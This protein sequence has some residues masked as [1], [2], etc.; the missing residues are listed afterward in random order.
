VERTE[1]FFT[2][3]VEVKGKAS[4]QESLDLFIQADILDGD[5]KYECSQCK[6]KVNAKKRCCINKLPNNLIIHLKR[7]D[8]D[9]E[10]LRRSKV[11]R[12]LEF[13]TTL[14]LE[15]YTKEGLARL[16][17]AEAATAT[18]DYEYELSGV[19]VHT[20]TT[21]SGHYYSYCKE[22]ATGLWYKFN[23]ETVTPF[24]MQPDA[25][26]E[27]WYG[28][29]YTS[30]HWDTHTGRQ[31]PRTAARPNSA[32]ML[33]YERYATFCVACFSVWRVLFIA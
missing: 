15:P 27:A 25:M 26:A 7:F 33:F 2:V 4:L 16:E 31:Q 18:A 12:R 24:A 9:L 8:F 23:D 1:P 29:E 17:A 11:T 6:T 30:H 10:T 20:G 14:N 22:R 32:Y 28:G 19:L 5:N 13:P 3:S 21:D